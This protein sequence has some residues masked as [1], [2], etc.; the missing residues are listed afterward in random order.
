MKKKTHAITKLSC[1]VAVSLFCTNWLCAG[2]AT[3]SGAS[4]SATSY[5]VIPDEYAGKEGQFVATG[6]ST[7]QNSAVTYG[8][9][10]ITDDQA[11]LETRYTTYGGFKYT[12]TTPSK[13]SYIGSNKTLSSLEKGTYTVTITQEKIENTKIYILHKNFWASTQKATF[14]DMLYYAQ[15][16]YCSADQQIK[17][18]PS[19]N[20]STSSS[21]VSTNT[22][23]TSAYIVVYGVDNDISGEGSSGSS[24]SIDIDITTGSDDGVYTLIS[25]LFDYISEIQTVLNASD[26]EI[27]NAL[28]SYIMQLQTA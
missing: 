8:T 4:G 22:S 2:S 10:Y 26:E 18:Y 23:L 5:I 27:R 24:G 15:Y 6:T 25:A 13:I 3:V 28:N 7:N 1:A 9:P 11:Y 17:S 21:Q 19:A 14:D 16:G 12:L 20:L